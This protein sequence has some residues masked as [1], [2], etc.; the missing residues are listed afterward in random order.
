LGKLRVPENEAIGISRIYLG[1]LIGNKITNL[2]ILY[3]PDT[4]D[5][6]VWEAHPAFSP[7]GKY[8]FFASN[9]SKG[10]GGVDIWYKVN[11][12][13]EWSNPIN[14]GKVINTECDELSPF[15]SPDAKNLYFSSMGHESVGGFDI[16]NA[17]VQFND[18]L[19]FSE[20]KNIRFPMNTTFDELFPSCL[21]DCDS[22]LFYSSNQ[23]SLPQKSNE[24]LSDLNMFVKER[25]TVKTIE[26]GT[27]SQPKDIEIK[28]EEPL[29]EYKPDFSVPEPVFASVSQTFSLTGKVVNLETQL[30]VFNATITAKNPETNEIEMQTQT[31]E[32]G[33]YSISLLKGA[34]IEVVI[35]AEN[36]FYDS[37]KLR[38]EKNDT[39]S[40]IERKVELPVILTLRINFPYDEYKE[41]YPFTLD[42][43]GNE[44]KTT[45][46]NEINNLADNLLKAIN[47]ID[48]II[49]VGNTD[50]MGGV[51][52]NRVLGQRRV[53]FVVNELVKRNVPKKILFA[54]SAGKLEPLKK[55][56][57]EVTETYQKRLRRVTMEKILK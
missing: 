35:Q 44:T 41:P 56:K 14:C 38:V 55:R 8:L 36:L 48:K 17:K 27:L 33:N 9:R 53:E 40:T 24:A 45:W 4:L 51:E 47:K 37:F 6:N 39:T 12:N 21:G 11:Q 50:D 46:Q 10:I 22:V 23:F 28:V 32:N 1:K 25:I 31:D 15:V 19:T 57:D 29:V 52:Y 3:T 16:F 5:N 7:D 49:L 18:N 30:P 43:N 42:S 26:K 54:R 20:M 34:D 13:G 2:K